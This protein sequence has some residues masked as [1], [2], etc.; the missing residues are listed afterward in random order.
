ML[1]RLSSDAS[2]YRTEPLISPCQLLLALCPPPLAVPLLSLPWS[3]LVIPVAPS[4]GG[5]ILTEGDHAPGQAGVTAGPAG[6]RLYELGQT[7]SLCEPPSPP[8][9]ARLSAPLLAGFRG[10]AE[11][12]TALGSEVASP[13]SSAL[14]GAFSLL[15]ASVQHRPR[16]QG[17]AGVRTSLSPLRRRTVSSFC[18]IGVRGLAEGHL[19]VPQVRGRAAGVGGTPR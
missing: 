9:E 15:G 11:R 4:L 17:V 3:K 16:V 2:S 8:L 19:E 10:G 5:G 7:H 13:A 6:D 12:A 18:R 14:S 1:S